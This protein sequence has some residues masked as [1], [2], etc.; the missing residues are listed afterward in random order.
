MKF[1]SHLTEATYL[2]RTLGFLT[3]VVVPNKRTLVIR[4]PNLKSLPDCEILGTRVWFSAASGFNYLPTWELAEVDHGHLVCVNHEHVK[5]AFGEAIRNNVIKELIGYKP[6]TGVCAYETLKKPLIFL[7]KKT[8]S[9][10]VGL[11]HVAESNKMGESFMDDN[12]TNTMEVLNK[13]IKAKSEGHRA[14][15]CFCVFNTKAKCIKLSKNVKN[16]FKQ[17]IEKALNTGV[18]IVAYKA[19]IS[20]SEVSLTLAIPALLSENSLT[21][22]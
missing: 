7:Q 17:L 21:S 6:F 2:K 18:E 3:E 8:D 15:L 1:S 5:P 14:I 20:L 4:S 13:L 12:I 19:S 9:C 11:E 16:K 22:N 10:F